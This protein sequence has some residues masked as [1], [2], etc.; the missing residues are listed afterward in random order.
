MNGINAGELGTSADMARAALVNK[1]LEM[2][3]DANDGKGPLAAPLRALRGKLDLTNVGLMGHSRGGRGVVWQAA[4]IHAADLPRGV[5]LR[6]AVPLAPADYHVSDPDSPEHLNYL[7]TQIPFAVLAGDC[8]GGVA[9]NRRTFAKNAAG[10]NKVPFY[11]VDLAGANH[12][13]FNSEWAYDNDTS[14]TPENTWSQLQQQSAASRYIVSFFRFH[15]LGDTSAGDVVV[16]GFSGVR[17]TT[18]QPAS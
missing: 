1:H 17:V 11:E 2:L 5:R 15:M 6:A 8:D 18:H 13:F 10:R 4:D 16:N 7:I 9:M 3:R 12:N 14:C